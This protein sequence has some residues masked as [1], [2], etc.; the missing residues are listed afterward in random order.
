MGSGHSSSAN[1]Q[2]VSD[3]DVASYVRMMHSSD[4]ERAQR[5]VEAAGAALND[6]KE[7]T[8]CDDDGDPSSPTAQI[9][10]GPLA[11]RERSYS[12]DMAA[13]EGHRLLENMVGQ[14]F[15]RDVNEYV[16]TSR[17]SSKVLPFLFA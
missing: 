9:S 15:H 13:V 1:L 14:T 8:K 2:N 17:F 12:A 11:F 7:E 6:A 4:P 3:D 5:L 10:S 16:R